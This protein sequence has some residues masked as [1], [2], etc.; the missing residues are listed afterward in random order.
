MAALQRLVRLRTSSSVLL[1]L[2][3]ALALL[4]GCASVIHPYSLEPVPD[5][6]TREQLIRHAIFV[7]NS[8]LGIDPRVDKRGR[9]LD[10][11]GYARYVSGIMDGIRSHRDSS[12]PDILIRIH[13]GLNALRGAPTTVI[14]MNSAIRDDTAKRLYPLFIN[15]DSGILESY[16]EHLFFV[17]QG[18]RQSFDLIWAPF[19]LFADLGRAATRLPIVWW[20]QV[21]RTNS[22][23]ATQNVPPRPDT[24]PREKLSP[25]D[26][27]L[28]AYLAMNACAINGAF[29]S[30]LYAF[31]DSLR[32]SDSTRQPIV[33]RF[34]YHQSVGGVIRYTGP[35]IVLSLVPM[36]SLWALRGLEIEHHHSLWGPVIVRRT[37]NPRGRVARSL[38]NVFSW[39]PPK[40]FRADAPG[41][42]RNSRVGE[43]APSHK[44]D[45][46]AAL[47]G[48]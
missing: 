4:L 45:V 44:D 20:G 16:G 18:R 41:C 42:N 14:Q 15:W 3:P 37:T 8:G 40:V 10:S 47:R 32:R 12:S 33:S 22:C 43:Y 39:L 1:A 9:T 29:E 38:V 46:S 2:V 21:R 24:A 26:S 35:S 25:R 34:A 36:R 31:D 28:N 17:R 11:A 27:A 48:Q 5:S 30:N 23:L 6:A 7:D 19:H 13:G